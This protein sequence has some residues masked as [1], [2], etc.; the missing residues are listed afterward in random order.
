MNRAMEMRVKTDNEKLIY[1]RKRKVTNKT[2]K[3]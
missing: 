2:K 3:E 1:K